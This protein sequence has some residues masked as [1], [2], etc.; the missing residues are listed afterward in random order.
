MKK[1]LTLL[2]LFH[3]LFFVTNLMGS[4]VS[5]NPSTP[6]KAV[7]YSS[8]NLNLPSPDN[9]VVTIQPVGN[10]KIEPVLEVLLDD[11]GKKAEVLMYATVLGT[12]YMLPSYKETLTKYLNF[13]NISTELDFSNQSG[14]IAY[15]YFGYY[16]ED[17]N[18]LC[19]NVYTLKVNSE[20][21]N[22]NSTHQIGLNF[23]RYYFG[24]EDYFQPYTINNDL[25]N[26]HVP[27]IRHL[28][29]AGLTWD[30]IEPYDNDWHFENADE[31]IM[32]SSM[33]IIVALFNNQ[34]ASPTPPW[35]TNPANFQ[36][37]LGEDAKDYLTHIVER[38]APYVKYWEI[39]NEMDT[40]WREFSDNN[41]NGSSINKL[42]CYPID[43]F[44]PQ[45]QGYF[46]AQVAKFIKEHDSDAVIILPGLSGLGEY[47]IDT[48]LGGVIEGGGGSD[49]FDIVNYH[50]YSDWKL[51]KNKRENFT[52]TLKKLGVSDK[53]V[54]CTE[55]GSTSSATLTVRTNYPNSEESQAADI[56][57]RI[58]QAWALGDELVIW[59]TYISSD[60]SDANIWRAYG[61]KDSKGNNKKA[62]YSYKLLIDELV[63]FKSIDIV[64][65]CGDDEYCYK[66]TTEDNTVKYIVWG[67]G[68]SKTF[69]IPSG[70]TQ[71]TVAVP[72][73]NGSFNWSSVKEGANITLS[74]IPVL[75][76]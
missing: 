34:Y 16:L 51:F 59:H 2:F 19:Y 27:V 65:D 76:K 26:L 42:N 50:Y 36:K 32:N 39:G 11:I 30:V 33:E 54:W 64:E 62:Y 25:N 1:A 68:N 29:K 5:G 61:I 73:D 20:T 66:I 22:D 35:A 3:S 40:H 31:I 69:K 12:G 74:N 75:L 4:N 15:I 8:S 14:L 37:T 21:T 48:W 47:S 63:P 72:N 7:E 52:D 41:T 28:I 6:L 53:P 24:N 45:E 56:F 10:V 18:K 67:I 43:G 60:D 9:T 57:R 13:K 23:I 17:E 71:K 46:L 44:S 58:V 49:W 70:I 38:Y 55:T